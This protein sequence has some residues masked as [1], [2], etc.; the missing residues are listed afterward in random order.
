MLPA[1]WLKE[2]DRNTHYFHHKALQRKQKETIHRMMDQAGCWQMQEK[3][4]RVIL[5]YFEQIFTTLT[6]R[7]YMSFFDQV[8]W[9]LIEVMESQ[10]ATTFTSK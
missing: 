10:L 1:T 5:A 4:D 6:K 3:S 2:G 8:E 7:V 9:K